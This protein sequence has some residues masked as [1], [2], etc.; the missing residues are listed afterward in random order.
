MGRLAA[1]VA[2]EIGNPLS[3]V[4]GWL[5]VAQTKSA[6]DPELTGYLREMEG[7]VRRIDGIVRSLLDLGRPK[8]SQV[9]PVPV[10]ELVKTAARLVGSGPEFR[11]MVVETEIDPASWPWPT[12][13]P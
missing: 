12:P 3:G 6:G 5:S 13:G 8:R 1:G 10:A 4:L 11:E 7:E 9:G 2:H